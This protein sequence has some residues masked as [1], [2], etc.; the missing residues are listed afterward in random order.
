MNQ[1]SRFLS[2][3]IVLITISLGIIS[4]E[5]NEGFGGNSTIKGRLH[6]KQYNNDYSLLIDSAPAKEQDVFIIFGDD[7]DIGDK[8]NTNYDGYFEFNFLR[9]GKYTI[10]YYSEDPDLMDFEQKKEMLYEVEVGKKATK[11]L[12]DLYSFERLDYNDG[13]AVIKGRV[14]QINYRSNS[15]W[16][17]MFV[18]DTVIVLEKEVYITY[19]NQTYYDDRIRTTDDGTFEVKQLIKGDYKIHVISEDIKGTS[20]DVA[21]YKDTTIVN[22]TDT[23]DVGD[24]FIH[25]L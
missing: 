16:P 25:N 24:I 21:I 23:I 18:E 8:V 7:P 5:K 13:N 11:D 14:L 17:I 20:Q 1:K 19:N 4:C 22:A 9:E 10:Y 2:Y 6:L 12:G 15:R 3:A